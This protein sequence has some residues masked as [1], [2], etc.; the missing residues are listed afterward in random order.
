M[1]T[2]SLAESEMIRSEYVIPT[3]IDNKDYVQSLSTVRFP[4]EVQRPGMVKWVARRLDDNSLEMARAI[5]ANWV[6]PTRLS[7][8]ASLSLASDDGD[9]MC[10][11]LTIVS[12]LL[13]Y[14]YKTS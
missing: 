2:P 13:N 5:L 11:I 10:W 9:R 14:R 1:S 4:K 3:L 8:T 7:A 12:L 6:H